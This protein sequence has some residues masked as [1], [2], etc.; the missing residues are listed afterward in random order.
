[1]EDRRYH[2]SEV[3]ML[4]FKFSKN[5][6]LVLEAKSY[7]DSAGIRLEKLQEEHEIPKGKYKLFTSKT[8]RAVVLN[9]LKQDL[10]KVGMADSKTK[11]TLGLAAGKVYKKQSDSIRKYMES[12][13]WFFWSPEDI[14]KKVEVTCR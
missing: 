2:V 5:E 4:G 9:R 10:I 1:M 14:K 8:Y 11:I 3:D 7:L 13:N 12:N 6:I